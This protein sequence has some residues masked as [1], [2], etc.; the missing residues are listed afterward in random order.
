MV[1]TI[2]VPSFIPFVPVNMQ[3]PTFAQVLRKCWKHSNNVDK[4]KSVRSLWIKIKESGGNINQ[5][6]IVA[7]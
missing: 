1:F 2:Y 5:N 6:K 4:I 7:N 3:H